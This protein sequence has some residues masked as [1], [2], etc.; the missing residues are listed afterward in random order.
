MNA[1]LFDPRAV[2]EL[3]EQ[4]GALSTFFQ[5]TAA[6]AGIASGLTLLGI[7]LGLRSRALRAVSVVALL[8][9]LSLL[10]A[11][12]YAT[13]QA[14]QAADAAVA[15]VT[16]ASVAERQRRAAHELARGN[17]LLALGLSAVPLA[18]G[19][20]GLTVAGRRRWRD[21]A[22]RP[23]HLRAIFSLVAIAD[24][25]GFAGEAVAWKMPLPGRDLDEMGWKV[26]ELEEAIG[27]QQFQA[28]LTFEAPIENSSRV[29]RLPQ[30]K[31]N[32]RRC[33]EHFVNA[34]PQPGADAAG[35]LKRLLAARW[36]EDEALR[37]KAQAKVDELTQ[38][39]PASPEDPEAAHQ[40]ALAEEEDSARN[41][42]SEVARACFE[43][44]AARARKLKVSVT[45]EL[46]VGTSGEV[47]GVEEGK[48][49]LEPATLRKCVFDAAKKLKLVNTSGAER[50]L[51][52]PIALGG[53][54]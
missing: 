31:D 40:K 28:C 23:E 29:R 52:A 44:A 47:K 45:L 49:A 38:P 22:D 24:M 53:P 10:G 41:Q 12:A 8:G 3:L 36:L 39:S 14:D 9:V 50:H 11:G 21:D 48:G 1:S 42:L 34:A 33:V 4:A 18:L 20:L 32:Q 5:R 6:V 7:L 26:V 27:R 17:L 2:S 30:F 13:Y 16:P 37:K 54:R 15:N 43:K 25:I 51:S 19:L 46:V 35:D